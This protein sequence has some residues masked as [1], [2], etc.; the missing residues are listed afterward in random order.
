MAGPRLVTLEQ[1]EK[2]PMV[3]V[4]IEKANEHLAVL[5]FTE[6]EF[7]HCRLVANRARKVLQELDGASREAELAAIAGYLHDIGNVMG[8]E[9]TMSPAP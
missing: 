8:A 1:V 6:H 9:N 4:F 2:H 3:R 5:G 7:R